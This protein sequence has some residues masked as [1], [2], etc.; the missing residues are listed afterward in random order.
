MLSIPFKD[1]F[2]TTQEVYKS[3]IRIILWSLV[4]HAGLGSSLWKVIYIRTFN[5]RIKVKIL[6]FDNVCTIN[7]D[8]F[9]DEVDF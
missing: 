8:Y 9:S 5:K 6:C 7:C 3:V 1:P 4:R 2:F